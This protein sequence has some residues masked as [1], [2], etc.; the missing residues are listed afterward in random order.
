VAVLLAKRPFERAHNCFATAIRRNCCQH[1]VL[2]WSSALHEEVF[3]EDRTQ[4]EAKRI[5][6]A[7][8]MTA[9]TVRRLPE[10]PLE[11]SALAP[12]AINR[13]RNP[14]ICFGVD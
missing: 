7:Q 8:R 9:A 3:A 10:L 1:A 13:T 5:A 11:R 2:F 6:K 14:N 12:A 4:L